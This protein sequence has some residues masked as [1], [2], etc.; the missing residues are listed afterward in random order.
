M[1]LRHITRGG[2]GGGGQLS[3]ALVRK[4]EESALMWIKKF[5]VC[6]HLLVQFLIQNEI[7][8]VSR[9]SP[10]R[11]F[12]CRAFLSRLVGECLLKCPYSKKTPLP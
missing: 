6:G 7:L 9:G 5:P 4:L 12:P 10:H 11:L 3:P 2:G 1:L 8:R